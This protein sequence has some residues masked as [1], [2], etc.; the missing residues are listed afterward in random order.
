M[1]SPLLGTGVY[2][3]TYY[4]MNSSVATANKVFN[5]LYIHGPSPLLVWQR[6]VKWTQPIDKGWGWEDLKM[7]T[8][9]KTCRYFDLWKTLIT[10]N[11]LIVWLGNYFIVLICYGW[12]PWSSFE[13]ILIESLSTLLGRRHRKL[14]EIS[15]LCL[16]DYST[17]SCRSQIMPP[18]TGGGLTIYTLPCPS[19]VWI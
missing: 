2:K 13:I 6:S 14:E 1:N 18:C 4:Q 11:I 17:C 10:L 12:L 9:L 8:S 5:S 15:W 7:W 16:I 3:E 19:K